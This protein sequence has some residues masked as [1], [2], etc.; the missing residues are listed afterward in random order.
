MNV[1]QEI[2]RSWVDPRWVQQHCFVEIDHEIHVFPTVILT[3][4]LIQEGQRM[5]TSTGKLSEAIAMKSVDQN[6]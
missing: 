1:Q 5:C 2:R 6:V 3:L 4:L